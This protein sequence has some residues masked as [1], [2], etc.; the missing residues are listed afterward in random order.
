MRYDQYYSAFRCYSPSGRFCKNGISLTFIL[1][2]SVPRQ[3]HVGT[4]R[5]W[6]WNPN[7]SDLGNKKLTINFLISSTVTLEMMI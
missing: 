4:V 2:R 6:R 3:L 7:H 5:L 1:R